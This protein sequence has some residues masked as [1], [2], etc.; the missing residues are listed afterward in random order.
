M[1][2][3]RTLLG[4]AAG[5]LA[6]PALVGA[7]EANTLRITGWGGA[8]G[9]VMR[10]KHIP[11]FE[12]AH[13]CTVEVDTAFPF[14]PK[15]LASPRGR[16]VYDVLHTNSNEQWSVYEQGLVEQRPDL[17]LVPN[18]AQTYPYAT[19]DSIVGIVIFTSA[20]GLAWRRDR[21]QTA[22]TS[23]KD[24]WKPEYAGKRASYVIPAN[25]LGQALFMMAGKVYGKGFKD[26]D[27]AFKAMEAVKPVRLFDF[28]G[29]AENAI[30]AGELDIA[31]LH[32]TAVYRNQDKVPVEF[33]APSEGIMA[34]EQVLSV[35]TG[36]PK[37]A[38]AHE[39]IN[40]M[41]SPDVQRSMAETV[42]YS[43]VRSDV[44]L[45]EKYRG[46]LLTTPEQVATLVQMP[47]Q[48]Y[49]ENKD[50]IDDRVNRIF[51]G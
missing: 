41:L 16:P 24:F 6:M 40:F 48:W 29:G 13:N 4:A 50:R 19:S 11:T 38:L 27:A 25:S 10:S 7:Q 2:N 39:W 14:V 32:D 35:T 44:T 47:W 28:T 9:E 23:W 12:K 26:L 43:P 37:K 51:R 49:N 46:K 3:R 31:V 15:L 33:A 8:W 34:L 18:A 21:I 30:L 5:T 36:T 17:K 45:A 1:L 20:I 42:W 22:P